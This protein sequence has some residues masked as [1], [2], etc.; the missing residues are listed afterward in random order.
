MT[1]SFSR[2]SIAA[3]C[4][5]PG[6]GAAQ[7]RRHLGVTR[8]EALHVHLVDDRA[9]PRVAGRPVVAPSRS[10]PVDARRAF[11]T[12]AAL[13]RVVVREV[14]LGRAEPVAED[15]APRSRPRREIARAYG[16]TSSFAGLK[17][18]PAAGSYGP[19]ARKP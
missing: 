10:R 17:R 15:R 19:C 16:S 8:R 18:S 11:G 6:V 4:A 3:G 12:P 1:P 13:S 14:A 5:K 2:C 7:L 9:V